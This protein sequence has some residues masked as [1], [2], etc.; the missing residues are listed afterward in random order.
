MNIAQAPEQFLPADLLARFI[1]IVGEKNAITDPQA[2]APYLVEMR[3]MFTGHTPLVLRPGSVAEVATILALANETGDRDRPAGRQYRPGRRADAAARR[4]RALAQ[5]ARPHPR[6]RSRLQ[7][8]D[9]RGRRDPAAGARSRRRSRPALSAAA[10]VGGHLHHRRQSLDQCRRHRRAR[11][12]HRAL[13]RARHRGGARRRARAAQPQQAQEGQYRLRSQEPV[14]RRGRHAR[15]DHRR[16]AAA[17]AA[18]ALGGNR[19]RRRAVAGG[20]ARAARRS[21]PSAPPA[22]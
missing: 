17:G 1:A 6:G 18:A 16:G 7:H 3:D 2:Q 10:A 8:H 22:A 12:R 14:H 11:P 13:A 5:P 9:L 15:R 4:D 21:P 19:V 20:G